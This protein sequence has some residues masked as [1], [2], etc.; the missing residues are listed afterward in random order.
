[1]ETLDDLLC[2]AVLAAYL[3]RFPTD[4]MLLDVTALAGGPFVQ[5]IG[6]EK[7]A[8]LV[9]LYVGSLP[10][11]RE[12]LTCQILPVF[13]AWFVDMFPRRHHVSSLSR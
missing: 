6:V 8:S 7:V 5:A 13:C 10:K 11:E 12:S 4:V 3:E 9:P 1:M 2:D